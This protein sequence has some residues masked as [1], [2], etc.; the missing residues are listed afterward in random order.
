MPNCF[1]L[2]PKGTNEPENLNEV[3]RKLC[4]HFN[5]PV[6]PKFWFYGWF[7][8]IGFLIACKNGCTLG[9]DKLRAEVVAWYDDREEVDRAIMLAILGYLEEN[10]TSNAWVEIGKGR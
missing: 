3:D 2:Y 9:S 6:D 7:H 4:E 8:V 1:Q 10:Y 5:S